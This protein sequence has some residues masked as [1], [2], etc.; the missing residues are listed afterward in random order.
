MS[1][2]TEWALAVHRAVWF[3]VFWLT[4]LEAAA[5]EDPFLGYTR[6]SPAD[7]ASS[8]LG[9]RSARSNRRSRS[10]INPIRKAK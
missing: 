5:E 8:C 4:G 10:H 2:A 7:R 6:L 9:K 1:F 3:P